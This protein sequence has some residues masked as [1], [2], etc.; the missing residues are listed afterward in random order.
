M[1][2]PI[3]RTA[4]VGKPDPTPLACL[5]CQLVGRRSLTCTRADACKELPHSFALGPLLLASWLATVI[6]FA[7]A[8][9]R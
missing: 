3:A 4:A 2:L 7:I 1:P 6:A 5:R 9:W 8:V